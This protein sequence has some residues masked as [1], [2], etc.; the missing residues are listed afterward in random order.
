MTETDIKYLAGLLD[1]DGSFFLTQT[2]SYLNLVIGL[3]LSTGIDREFKYSNWLSQELDVKYYITERDTNAEGVSSIKFIV[4]KRTTLEKLIP[5]IL[6]YLVIKGKHLDRLWR[7]YKNNC[8]RKLSPEE[9]E[10]AKALNKSS[11][12][13]VGPLRTKSWLPKAYVAGF[14]DGDGCYIMKTS[15]GTY[16][17]NTVSHEN[18]RIVADL[19]FK[20]Y[21]GHIYKQEDWIR[22][23]RPLGRTN[24][25]FAIKFLRDMH[26]HSRLKTY[27][28]EQFLAYH[29]QRLNVET[30]TGD[31]IV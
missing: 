26:R 15:S 23:R 22:W 8:S 19:L 31:V 5:R 27:K 2:S 7:H 4:S 17:V 11:R 10:Y 29:S 1:A 12:L 20:Q 18:D 9:I 21:G 6:K 13:D 30:P 3:D 25:V 16:N 28:I 24:R 14:I